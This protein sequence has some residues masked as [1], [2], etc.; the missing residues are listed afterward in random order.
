[1]G[2][3]DNSMEVSVPVNLQQKQEKQLGQRNPA[4]KRQSGKSAA[5]I[6]RIGV[7]AAQQ[8]DDPLVLG[9]ATLPDN[10]AAS[11]TAPARCRTGPRE[12]GSLAAYCRAEVNAI[13]PDAMIRPGRESYH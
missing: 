5:E 2:G 11:A 6:D 3:V 7:R 10:S 4:A 1:M 8:H 9:R 12:M 13:R